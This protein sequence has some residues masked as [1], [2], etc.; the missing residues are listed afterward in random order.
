MTTIVLIAMWL[1]VPL[2]YFGISEIEVRRL[3]RALN[4]ARILYTFCEAR[5][6]MA[7]KA[8]R[9]EMD[10]R[11]EVFRYFYEKLGHIIHTHEAYPIGFAH[12]AKDLA[13][14][15][16]R[17]SPVWVRRLLRELKKSDPEVK[18]MVAHYLSA[19][20]L[21]VKQDTA[22]SLLDKL[23]TWRLEAGLLKRLTRLP[24]L[25]GEKRRFAKFSLA[26]ANV[27]EPEPQMA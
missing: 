13:E 12:L 10:E 25:S 21:V 11:S 26:L 27:I 15:R 19:I 17:P 5:D 14:N 1:L 4:H 2:V 23:P 20:E 7:V 24:L 9:G 6:F 8:L 22:I 16:N 18:K 3:R